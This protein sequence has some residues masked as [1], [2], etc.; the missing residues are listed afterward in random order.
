MKF[1][2]EIEAL[3][4]IDDDFMCMV[5]EDARCCQEVLGIILDKKDL[6][7]KETDIHREIKN[8][9]NERSVVL[10]VFA[11]DSEGKKYNIEVQRNNSGAIPQRAR[12]YSSIIDVSMTF[13]GE[14]Y[15]DIAESYVVFITENDV[16][17]GGLPIYHI[18]R[19]IRETNQLFNDKEH[20]VYVNASMR[21]GESELERLMHDFYCTS[22]KDIHN[23]EIARQ[24]TYFKESEE[25]K[26]KMCKIMEDIKNQGIEQGIK[27]GVEQGIAK[28]KI[29]T[30][31]KLASK[32]MTLNEIS[33][34]VN[35]SEKE[36][37]KLIDEN[38]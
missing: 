5:F 34:I 11:T 33:D 8:I 2:K 17:A 4:L 10:D 37:I 14:S 30:I 22:P 36:I 6:I 20:I 35:L 38:K 1:K 19:V 28:E 29:N 13:E 23:K 21:Y 12:Y 25:G 31:K 32:G 7:I 3:R 16:L 9:A 18:E 24:V 27:Q 15:K 26:F